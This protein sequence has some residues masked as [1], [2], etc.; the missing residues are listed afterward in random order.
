VFI[1]SP[2]RILSSAITRTL[3][4]TQFSLRYSLPSNHLTILIIYI[5]SYLKLKAV[6]YKSEEKKRHLMKWYCFDCVVYRLMMCSHVLKRSSSHSCHC[7]VSEKC[8]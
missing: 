4:F 6:M 1:C 2:S 8:T 3:P 5:I 7:K